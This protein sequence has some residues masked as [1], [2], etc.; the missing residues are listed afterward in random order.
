MDDRAARVVRKLQES[1]AFCVWAAAYVMSYAPPSRGSSP[2]EV[3]QLM[4]HEAEAGR[5]P[6]PAAILR[7]LSEACGKHVVTWANVGQGG[8]V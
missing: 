8:E 5:H 4:Q 6:V 7:A 2:A 3:M 1:R